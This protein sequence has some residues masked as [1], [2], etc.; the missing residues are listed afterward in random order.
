MLK[1]S[2]LTWFKV[3]SKKTRGVTYKEWARAVVTA[4]DTYSRA[5]Y[6][7]RRASI[8]EW[9]YVD[10]FIGEEATGLDGVK[11]YQGV[12]SNVPYHYTVEISLKDSVVLKQLLEV[13]T[14]I[15]DWIG[16]KTD[17]L[18]GRDH[19]EPHKHIGEPV[20]RLTHADWLAAC[21]AYEQALRIVGYAPRRIPI[22]DHV[23]AEI[24]LDLSS[25]TKPLV[26][27][28]GSRGTH[29]T[30]DYE[31][32][33]DAQKPHVIQQLLDIETK[34]KQWLAGERDSLPGDTGDEAP[35]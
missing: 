31:Y 8:G 33:A 5:A 4:W 21:E 29:R 14:S 28:E 35:L 2:E 6:D 34:V 3:P 17:T 20:A 27:V 30:W 10:Y 16:G 13:K 12:R 15:E 19:W 1:P 18:P 9:A 11:F 25:K 24:K 7:E 32:N 23:E 26:K 22:T